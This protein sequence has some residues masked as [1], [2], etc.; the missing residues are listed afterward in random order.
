MGL[1]KAETLG[2]FLRS[3]KKTLGE[4]EKFLTESTIKT[5]WETA[6]SLYRQGV[7][8]LRKNDVD[9][10]EDIKNANVC[11]RKIVDSNGKESCEVAKKTDQLNES[12]TN[13]DSQNLMDEAEILEYQLHSLYDSMKEAGIPV[14]MPEEE[15]PVVADD[16][17]G[18]NADV[19][20]SGG[21]RPAVAAE[22]VKTDTPV[23]A[24]VKPM[25][26]KVVEPKAVE[27]VVVPAANV[28][29]AGEKLAAFVKENPTTPVVDVKPET[30][31]AT[32]SSV[33][34][35]VS[36]TADKAPEAAPVM[37][38]NP[39]GV[40]AY[41]EGHNAGRK[42][43]KMGT[44]S[45]ELLNHFLENDMRD[46]AYS[47]VQRWQEGFHNGYAMEEEIRRDMGEIQDEE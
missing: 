21:S 26:N 3:D 6:V 25:D 43:W 32:G 44:K 16:K 24:D 7:Q 8:K 23:A 37:G 34:P 11:L 47:Y 12:Y 13:I 18:M 42:A 33:G 17:A 20:M 28:D 41:E 2:K 35:T 38:I 40:S 1:I 19:G 29:N 4:F 45:K 15:V 31:M 30:N 14:H 22:P 36:Q 10:M 39:S 27:P 5:E 46:H 9:G